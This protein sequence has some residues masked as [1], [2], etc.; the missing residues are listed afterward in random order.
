MAI[1][2][3]IQAALNSLNAAID[4]A[5]TRVQNDVKTLTDKIAALQAQ[6]DAGNASPEVVAALQAAQ[7]RLDMIDPTNAAVLPP[8]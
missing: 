6:I 3:T 5:T 8:A 2:P 1:D 4:A 7:A